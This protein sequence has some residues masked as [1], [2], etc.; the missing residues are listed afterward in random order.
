VLWLQSHCP[1]CAMGA[2]QIL[3]INS[4]PLVPDQQILIG[5][6]CLDAVS[7]P[8][9]KIF[10]VTSRGLAGSN[11]PQLLG[12]PPIWRRAPGWAIW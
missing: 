12:D 3:D 6:K 9:Y 10:R 7:E 4:L 5:R 8:L 1:G 11:S 2:H